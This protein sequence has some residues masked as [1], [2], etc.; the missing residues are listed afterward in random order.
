VA[1]L[2]L[3][4]SYK[5]DTSRIVVQAIASGLGDLQSVMF[6]EPVEVRSDL[7]RF[8]LKLFSPLAATLGW[9]PVAGEAHENAL[10]RPLVLSRAGKLGD[11]AVF[12]ESHG[13]FLRYIGGDKEA[14][15][16]DLREAV[17]GTVLRK[18]G[19]HEFDALIELY[20]GETAADQKVIILRALGSAPDRAVMEA[21]MA[22]TMSS[23]VRDQDTFDALCTMDSATDPRP[24]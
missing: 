24:L 23:E 1:A 20:K 18:G 8:A 22:F 9:E 5:G 3:L 19:Q 13:R 7:K 4:S 2:T 14:I 15:H 16:P 10:L 17:F 12:A 6:E 21:A 11:E